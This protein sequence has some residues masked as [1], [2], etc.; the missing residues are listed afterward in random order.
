MSDQ[1]TALEPTSRSVAILGADALLVAL[2]STPTQLANACFAGGF[3]EVFPATWGDELIAAG[4]LEQLERRSGP[5]IFCA[6]PLVAEQLRGAAELLRFIVPLISPPVAVARYLRSLY[7]DAALRIT[8]VGDCPGADDR[9]IDVRLSPHELLSTLAKR[10][11]LPATQRP[12]LGTHV[13]HDRRRFYSLPGG[14][15]SPQWLGAQWP[16]RTLVDVHAGDALAGLANQTLS[17]GHTL[18][19]FAPHLGCACAGAVNGNDAQDA[20]KAVIALEP[21][22]AQSEIVNAAVHVEVSLAPAGEHHVAD[23]TWGDFL[24]ALPAALAMHPDDGSAPALAHQ[25]SRAAPRRAIQKKAALPRAY[26]AARAGAR[27]ER[28]P[29]PREE[30][31]Q[32][33]A[34]QQHAQRA[35]AV[36]RSDAEAAST[37]SSA[38][39]YGTRREE[40]SSARSNPWIARRASYEGMTGPRGVSPHRAGLATMDRWLLSGLMLTS[41][42]LIAVLT[43]ALTVRGMQRTPAPALAASAPSVVAVA[44]TP[45]APVRDTNAVGGAPRTTDSA[46]VA[47][48]A[49]SD[50]APNREE[51]SGAVAPPPPTSARLSPM[52]SQSAHVQ[53]RVAPR[54]ERHP[55]SIAEH[56]RSA[57]SPSARARTPLARDPIAAPSPSTGPI[58]AQQPVAEPS[59]TTPGAASVSPAAAATG[60]PASTAAAP[61]ANNAQFLEELRAIRAEIN[62]RKRHMDS[63]TASLDSLKHVSKPE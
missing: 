9:A 60:T 14:V 50:S 56:V 63:L 5:A 11:I 61:A 36:A 7:P 44:T 42:V 17:R 31:T 15:P 41:S 8:Y 1:A 13:A 47:V 45:V 6:C 21:P 10:G 62:A 51:A 39:G 20:R 54:V 28:S 37:A 53:K 57:P 55:V 52:P 16:K 59:L 40:I 24:A 26:M 4:C 46:L 29:E 18:I 33:I 3:A 19:D 49:H 25:T 23:V 2:P 12:D 38:E 32:P 35:T 48:T 27:R 34:S 30:A 43:S 22:R 58:V